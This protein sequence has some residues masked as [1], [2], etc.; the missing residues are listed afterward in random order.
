MSD[1]EI[2]DPWLP[3]FSDQFESNHR[4][5]IVIAPPSVEGYEPFRECLAVQNCG[6]LDGD[7]GCLR[8]SAHR[9]GLLEASA[10]DQSVARAQVTPARCLT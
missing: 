2:L 4:H 6:R 9:Q 8:I 3:S 7:H 5:W 1:T 10:K